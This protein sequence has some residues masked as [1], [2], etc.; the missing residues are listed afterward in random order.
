MLHH[1]TFQPRKTKHNL[2]LVKRYISWAQNYQD[3]ARI[4]VIDESARMEE[5]VSIYGE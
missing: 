1:Q 3:M 5:M 2:Q 4:E